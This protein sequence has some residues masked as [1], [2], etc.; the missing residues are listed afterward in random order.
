MLIGSLVYLISW[1]VGLFGVF[2]SGNLIA[3][4]YQEKKF[5]GLG[6]C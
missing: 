2:C 6:G 5:L 4:I 1:N 3:V